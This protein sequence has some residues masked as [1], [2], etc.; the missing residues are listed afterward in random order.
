VAEAPRVTLRVPAGLLA[1]IERSRGEADLSTWLR[2][3]ATQRLEAERGLGP[4]IT[5]ALLEHAKQLRGLGSNLNQ[6]ARA[7]NER[8]PVTVSDDLL[9]AILREIAATRS[10]LSAVDTA[11]R[12]DAPDA[13]LSHAKGALGDE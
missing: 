13:D 2:E 7:A 4:E 5:T 11:L 12:G 8:R 3:A 10:M 9:R 1:R 6:L